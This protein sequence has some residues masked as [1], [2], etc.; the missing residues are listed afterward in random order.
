MTYFTRIIISISVLLTGAA[1][2]AQDNQVCVTIDD[3]PIQRPSRY[4]APKQKEITTNILSSLKK[5]HIPAIGF[6]NENKLYIDGNL[7][8]DRK[9]LLVQWL[10][11]GMELGNHTFSHPDYN[12]ATFESFKEEIRTG[13]L[14]S[15]EHFYNDAEITRWPESQF[16][17]A[18]VLRSSFRRYCNPK[19]P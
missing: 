7:N 13:Q 4:M 19:D 1:L 15:D 5:Y 10:E 3:L 14:I 2:Y 16:T 12:K 17:L 6:V 18:E 9:Q 8:P 11:S